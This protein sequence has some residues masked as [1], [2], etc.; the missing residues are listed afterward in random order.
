MSAVSK[1]DKQAVAERWAEILDAGVP[2]T[3]EK[4]L[5]GGIDP[6][7]EFCKDWQD[8][9]KF[10]QAIQPLLPQPGPIIVGLV[11]TLGDAAFGR[12]CPV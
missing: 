1:A 8:V 6:R 12:L 9:K 11:I 4:A 7:E 2:V 3:A 5:V 10:L